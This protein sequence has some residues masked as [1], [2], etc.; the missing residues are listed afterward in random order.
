MRYRSNHILAVIPPGEDGLSVLKHAMFFQET[1]GMQVFLYRIVEKQ[2]FFD[3]IFHAKKVKIQR[4]QSLQEIKDFAAIH[5][6]EHRLKNFTYRVRNG[7]KLPILL[8]ASKKGGYE[9]IITEKDGKSDPFDPEDLD[10]F[11][12]LTN[13]PVMAIS[14]KHEIKQ[15]K[16]IVIPVDVM[17]T[18]QKKLLWATYFA[19]K[20]N[21]KITIVSALSL[22]INL[23]QSVAW[24]NAEKMKHLLTQRGI[25]CEVDIIKDTKR[26]KHEV[27]LDFI[28]KAKADL[29]IIRT[30]QE[31]AGQFTQIGSFVSNLVHQCAVPVF[32][33]NRFLHPMP[34]DFEV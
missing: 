17:Q 18:T 30:H 9:F 11:I 26:E 5:I 31:T 28:N 34:V 10:R 33:V 21:A 19:R 24:R 1:L 7:K 8:N 14:N 2:S 15:I 20:Y 27:I 4:S 29:V 23:K 32:M 16:H 22:N 12:S 25:K 6:P 3:K 13:S